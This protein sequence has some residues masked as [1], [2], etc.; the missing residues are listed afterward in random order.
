MDKLLSIRIPEPLYQQLL[1]IVEKESYKDISELIRT[2]I[3][4]QSLELIKLHRKKNLEIIKQLE[5]AL[6]ELK[7]GVDIDV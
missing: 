7:K 2:K 5:Q 6:K 1:E 4:K 3:R